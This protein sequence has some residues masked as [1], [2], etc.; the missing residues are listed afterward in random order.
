MYRKE[1]KVYWE[2]RMTSNLGNLEEATMTSNMG[3]R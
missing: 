1:K 2:A 3:W